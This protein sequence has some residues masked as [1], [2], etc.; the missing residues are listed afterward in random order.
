MKT[1]WKITLLLWALTV[2]LG[3]EEK[4]STIEKTSAQEELAQKTTHSCDA[5]ITSLPQ[6]KT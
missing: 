2:C 5:P 4:K 1:F 3:R 6:G